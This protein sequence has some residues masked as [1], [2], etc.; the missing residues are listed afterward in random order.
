MF[1]FLGF[2][3]MSFTHIIASLM[4]IS[5]LLAFEKAILFIS[6]LSCLL[7]ASSSLF[8]LS[9]PIYKVKSWTR[10][11]LWSL[12]ILKCYA[13][14]EKSWRVTQYGVTPKDKYEESYFFT[15]CRVCLDT[16]LV[17]FHTLDKN[18]L[19]IW[20]RGR[21]EWSREIVNQAGRETEREVS[22]G[23]L[24]IACVLEVVIYHY[25]CP[26]PPLTD[27]S[28]SVKRSSMFPVL[29]KKKTNKKS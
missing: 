24:W 9:V 3:T 29:R 14:L 26:P 2:K 27:S 19:W 8:E 25:Y 22:T 11:S 16:S 7:G 12:S 23:H 17:R 10:Y 5:L 21:Q 1:P 20:D 6:P 15:L 18:T 13:I 28:L 4:V